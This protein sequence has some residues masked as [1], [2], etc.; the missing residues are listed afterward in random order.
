MHDPGIRLVRSRIISGFAFGNASASHISPYNPCQVGVLESLRLNLGG[1]ISQRLRMADA[2]QVPNPTDGHHVVGLADFS[3]IPPAARVA[4]SLLSFI[5]TSILIYC[6]TRR[7]Q[8]IKSFKR[9][10]AATWLL[11]ATYVDSLFFIVSTAVLSKDFA[12]DHS[13]GLCDSAILI[14]K[15]CSIY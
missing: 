8:C 9:V 2:P 12:L 6:L 13:L 4:T 5:S 15:P 10:K 3:N 11:L 7:I 14:C 1:R